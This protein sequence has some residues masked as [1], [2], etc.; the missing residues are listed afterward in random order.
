VLIKT[1]HDRHGSLLEPMTR[2]T[3]AP[4]V[5]YT[6]VRTTPGSCHLW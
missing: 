6:P 5:A 2:T 1:H 3:R 4:P